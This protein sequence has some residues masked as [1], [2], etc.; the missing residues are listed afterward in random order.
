MVNESL[1][2]KVQ[3]FVRR[4]VPWFVVDAVFAVMSFYLA[5][6]LRF[7]GTTPE[8][9]FRTLPVCIPFIV[10]IY[11]LVNHLFGIYRGMWRYASAQEVVTILSS[12]VASTLFLVLLDLLWTVHPLP[13]SVVCL[14]GFFTLVS[15]IAVRYRSRVVHGTLL[16]WRALWGHWPVP[17][18]RVL[19]V[20]VGDRGQ[21]LA[22][23]LL[24]QSSGQGYDVVGFI[25]DDP[26]K[27]GMQIHGIEILGDRDDIRAVARD[28]SADLIIIARDTVS[29]QDFRDVLSI[30]LETE[31]QVMVLPDVFEVIE[32]KN[33]H[34]PVRDIT[35]EDL[36]GR[37]PAQ[38]DHAA[39][40]ELLAGKV[41]MV[42][43]ASGSIGSEL[44]LQI[45][46]FAPQLL[47]M[48]DNNESGL[49]DL[50]VELLG[51]PDPPAMLPV[52]GDITN[53][54]KM[55]AI[56]QEHRPQIVFHAAAYKHVPLLEA[57]PDEAVRVNIGGTA[58][59]TELSH[60][61]G[62]GRFVFVC[63]DKAVEPS[64]IM[65]GT[66]R[67]GEMLVSCAP[68][69]T[70]T[71]HTSVR[72]GN[73]LGSRGSVVPTFARQIERGGP[74]T[75]THPDMTRYFMSISEAVSLIIQA[76]SFAQGGG[77]FIL[78]MGEQIR[79]EDLAHKM[80]RLRGL[81]PGVD[82]PIV[83]MGTR[84][85]EKLHEKLIR[86]G[87]ERRPTDH[88]RIS[89]VQ[90]NHDVDRDALLS[91]IDQLVALANQQ[92]IGEMVETL[93]KVVNG[94]EAPL[95]V[96]SEM[97]PSI[98]TRGSSAPTTLGWIKERREH[99]R[100]Q[101]TNHLMVLD[102][103]AEQPLGH[104]AD[105]TAGGLKLVSSDPIETNTVYHLRMVLPEEVGGSRQLA[106]DARSV[107]CSENSK[108]GYYYVGFQSMN[109]APECEATIERLI[110]RFG[111]RYWEPALTI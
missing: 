104:L 18:K 78:D 82:I 54:G 108:V 73:V 43:G 62:V 90:N 38:I 88:P 86:E 31:A 91:Q 44:C 110:D 50:S 72:F 92:R 41:I 23:Q 14:G 70:R 98:S 71:I 60:R 95:E 16:R 17:N 79:I 77:T 34:P 64:C 13:L 100:R 5:L 93:W 97:A 57:Q 101:M 52:L 84:P 7:A 106:L 59:L 37:K 66:K 28:K 58:I 40:R 21:L 30:C 89:C 47:V 94:C 4:D 48:V 75:V 111:S 36:L 81:R 22:W 85:G 109:V 2:T 63:T 103:N 29:G 19:V 99:T 24:N 74:V 8:Y 12:V 11:C 26:D 20:D 46:A 33:G 35:P 65:G 39:C 51:R 10:G 27:L 76:A 68:E 42:T 25:D 87:E 83:Y 3:R 61:Y 105:I 6:F 56:F 32:R 107:W 67:I 53:Q 15:F 1:V 49:H 55:E 69:G 9:Y 80:I 96:E 102:G 45:S